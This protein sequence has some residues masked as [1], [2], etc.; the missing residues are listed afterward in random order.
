MTSSF[1]GLKSQNDCI[2]PKLTKINMTR[3][4]M[5]PPEI[6]SINRFLKTQ[7]KPNKKKP[8]RV[9]KHL[10]LCRNV[11][12]LKYFWKKQNGNIKDPFNGII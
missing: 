8:K 11:L 3:A 4:F 1:A 2:N 7:P 6:R 5:Y 10:Q 9:G 12:K